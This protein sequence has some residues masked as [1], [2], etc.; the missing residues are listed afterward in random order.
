VRERDHSKDPGIHGRKILKWISR[1]RDG[2]AWTGL[3]WLTTGTGDKEL[4]NVV[5]N[6][7]VP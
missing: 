5:M 7:Q 4:V 3:I 6:F 1:T 2:R